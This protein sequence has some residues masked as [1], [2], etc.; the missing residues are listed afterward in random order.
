MTPAVQVEHWILQRL[1]EPALFDGVT[2]PEERRERVRGL[3]E[4]RQLHLAIAGRGPS[5]KCETWG[6]LYRRIYGCDL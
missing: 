4:R 5:G 2:T 6:A 3:I 1:D